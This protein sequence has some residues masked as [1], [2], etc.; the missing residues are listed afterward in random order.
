[1]G[2]TLLK[3][4]IVRRGISVDEIA[5]QCKISESYASKIIN[6]RAGIIKSEV[7]ANMA[8]YLKLSLPKL[9]LLRRTYVTEPPR[10]LSAIA[11]EG[12]KI[13]FQ[14]YLDNVL[15]SIDE[16]DQA[17]MDKYHGKIVELK[18]KSMDIYSAYIA[19]YDGWRLLLEDKLEGSLECF[20]EAQAFN[21]GNELEIRLKSQTLSG[22]GEALIAR[23]YYR[24]SMK[25]LRKSLMMRTNGGKGAGWIYLQM[26]TLFKR[27]GDFVQ[28]LVAYRKAQAFGDNIIGILALSAQSQLE[29]HKDEMFSRQLVTQAFQK[30]KDSKT[31]KLK[32]AIY[33][34]LGESLLGLKAFDNAESLF[35]ESIQYSIAEGDLR[36]KHRAMIGLGNAYVENNE[37]TLLSEIVHCIKPEINQEGDSINVWGKLNLLGV[38]HM[39][40]EEFDTAKAILLEAYRI[41]QQNKLPL[42]MIFSCKRLRECHSALGEADIADFYGREEKRIRKMIKIR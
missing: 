30:V 42:E 27:K 21:A 28:A 8:Y 35:K 40:N 25:A 7:L 31:L 38:Y 26:G 24:E 3:K 39:K 10:S 6:N 11:K 23:G 12:T 4:Y 22:L 29:P 33:G 36:S 32:G 2:K 17:R 34:S 5:R 16:Y 19:G 37:Q 1:M 18:D 15:T 20:K 9:D 14:E 13:I 41:A